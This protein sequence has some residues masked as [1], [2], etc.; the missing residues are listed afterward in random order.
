MTTIYAPNKAFN[1][2]TAGVQF[3]NGV[4]N[5]DDSAAL[6]YLGRVGYGIGQYR[7]PAVETTIADARDYSQPVPLGT[8]LRDAAVDP[9]AR[10][11]LPPINAGL[12]DPHGP[13]VVSPQ[14]HADATGPIVPGDVHVGEPAIQEARETAVDEAVFV[15]GEPVPAVV[16]IDRP[17]ASASKAEWVE[18]ATGQGL[19]REEAEDLTKAELQALAG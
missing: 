10:D 7:P 1:G 3:K 9:R 19:S 8:R 4:G 16:S 17:G 15:E 14:I 6:S 18:F 13:D 11:F 2:I 12:A 5:T